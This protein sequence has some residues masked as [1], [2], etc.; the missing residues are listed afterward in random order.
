MDTQGY[1]MET[2]RYMNECSCDIKNC[3]IKYLSIYIRNT[4]HVHQKYL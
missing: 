4:Y 2:L 3:S 1:M